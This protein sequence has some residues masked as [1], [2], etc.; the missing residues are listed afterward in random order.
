LVSVR[1]I[2]PPRISPVVFE[3]AAA[4]ITPH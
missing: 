1:G 3:T 2:E 4:T